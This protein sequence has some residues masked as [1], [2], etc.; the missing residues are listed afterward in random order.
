MGAAE[1]LDE[2]PAL[3]GLFLLYQA[4][5]FADR[6]RVKVCSKSRQIGISWTTAAEAVLVAGA[7]AASGGMDVW[8]MSQSGRDATEFTRDAAEFARAMDAGLVDVGDELLKDG[9]ASILVTVIKFASGFRITLLPGTRPNTLRGKKGYVIF[10]EAALLNLLDCRAAAHALRVWGG[11]MAFISTQSD[12]GSEWNQWLEEILAGLSEASL[13]VITIR[14]ACN[15]GLYKRICLVNGETWG[16]E[17]EADWIAD[18]LAGPRAEREF[19]CIPSR[20]SGGYFDRDVVEF[21]ME[22]V[23][24]LRLSLTKGWEL[25]GTEDDR[26]AHVEAWIQTWLAPELAKLNPHQMHALGQDFGRAADGDLSVLAPVAIDQQLHRRAPF[27]VELRGVPFEQQ[28]QIHIALGD[29]LPKLIGIK[30]D[31]GGNG[32]YL[33]EKSQQHFGE[34]IVEKVSCG[35]PWYAEHVPR[36]KAALERDD[37]TIP[38]DADVLEDHMPWKVDNNIPI[39]PKKREKGTDGEQR[40]GDAAVAL[41]LGF[42]A[43][44]MPS[45]QPGGRR[46]QKSGPWA[47]GSGR[48]SKRKRRAWQ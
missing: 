33:A 46:V 3:P 35:R 44:S 38:K 2:P 34:H 36:Y 32:A 20:V 9:E 22:P 13:H 25:Q 41:V 39:L 47:R 6:S 17:A 16:E 29:G 4:K 12:E 1:Q 37:L 31:Q 18:L 43:S 26:V 30:I 14:D 11:R 19:L 23:P 10:D 7:S 24:I 42:Q 15:D 21:R 45:G 8:Y 28:K 5:W 48:G 27:L 40:H